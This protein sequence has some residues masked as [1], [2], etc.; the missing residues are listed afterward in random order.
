MASVANPPHQQTDGAITADFVSKLSSGF[1]SNPRYRQAMNAV[2]TTPI[3]KVALNRRKV[4]EVD[5]TF[6]HHL[7]ENKITAQMQSG[8][9]WMF[10]A[11]NTF[12]VEAIKKMNL[13]NDFELSQ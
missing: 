5:H 4:V 10:A 13:D 11:L 9:C 6:S 7:P 1:Q 2:C 3:T 12:R 8:R